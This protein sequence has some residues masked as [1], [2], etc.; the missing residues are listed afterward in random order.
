MDR[1][2]QVQKALMFDGRETYVDVPVD[3]FTDIADVNGEAHEITVSLWHYGDI[4]TWDGKPVI[5]TH[6]HLFFGENPDHHLDDPD[7]SWSTRKLNLYFLPN[8]NTVYAT[9]GSDPN[10]PTSINFLSKL[11]NLEDVEDQWNHWALTKDANAGEL[12]VYLNGALWT[13]GT[14]MY[15][16]VN[17]I[18]QF[19]IGA[20]MNPGPLD[21]GFITGKLDDFRIY[22]YALSQGEICS[23]A[24]MTIGSTYTQPMQLLLHSE[25]NT[26]IYEDNTIDFKDHAVL[27]QTWLEEKIW[28]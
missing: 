16:S 5:K 17:G 9:I 3:V 4:L 14:G 13:S 7:D 12:K 21:K 10:E 28:P 11:P 22:D 18:A 25:A 2:D 15:H 20:V 6:R 23:L 19:F 26:N 1:N 27:A 8:S 24:D